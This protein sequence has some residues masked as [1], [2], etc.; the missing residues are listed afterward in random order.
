MLCVVDRCTAMWAGESWATALG[1]RENCK[2]RN[3][4]F[5]PIRYLHRCR[6]ALI[7]TDGDKGCYGGQGG[8]LGDARTS[9]MVYCDSTEPEYGLGGGLRGVGRIY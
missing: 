4:A 8:S 2:Y 7:D 6:F 1:R 3:P 9:Q 5:E